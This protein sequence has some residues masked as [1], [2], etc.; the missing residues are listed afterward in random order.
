MFS[1]NVSILAVLLCLSVLGEVILAQDGTTLEPETTTTLEDTTTFEASIVEAGLEDISENEEIE[2]VQIDAAT[3]KRMYNQFKLFRV[4][5]QDEEQLG[6]VRFIANGVQDLW[7]PIPAN[8]TQGVS[9]DMLVGP[10]HSPYVVKFLNCSGVPYDITIHDIQRV[11][12]EGN[13]VT[14]SSTRIANQGPCMAETG[15]SWD[16][17][18]RMNVIQNYMTCLAQRYSNMVTLHDLGRTNEGRHLKVVEISQPKGSN[19]PAIW[20]DGGIHA[21]EWISPA[22]VTFMLSELV[23]NSENHQNLLSKYSFYIMPVMNPDGYEYTHSYDRLWRKDRSSTYLS[24]CIGT[25][26]NRNWGYKYGGKGASTNACDE[27]YRGPNAFSAKETK[28][29]SNFILQ[30]AHNMKMFLTFHSYGQY[31]LYPWGYTA[32]D[33]PSNWRDLDRVGRIGAEAMRQKKRPY[34]FSRIRCQ[35]LISRCRWE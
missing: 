30:R 16:R 10:K 27:T 1:H 8:L 20:I 25:D 14:E 2:E 26:L 19:K 9:I 5:P 33:E 7:T 6:I 18:N 29:A 28:A 12:D 21:R 15:L 22:S 31:I 17:Y 24:T 34:L 11:I 23:E 32:N 13:E 4:Q 35:T 3:G